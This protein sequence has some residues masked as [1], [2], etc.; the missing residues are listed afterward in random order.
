MK[1][2]GIPDQLLR[3]ISAFCSGRT[4]TI[5]VNGHTS[6]RRSL[7]QAGL[8]Q[9]SPLSPILF[10]FFNADLV[11]R[12]IDCYRGAIA[13]VDDFTAWVTG[14]TAESNREGIEAIINDALAWERR[15][16]ATFE[17]DMTAIIHF[18][19]KPYKTD[20]TPFTIKGQSVQP[21]THVK[22]LGVI[23]DAKLKYKEHI[24]RAAAKGLEAVIELRRLKGLSPATARQLFTATVAP[25][26]DYASNVWMHECRGPGNRRNV[27][28]CGDKRGRSRGT[29]CYDAGSVLEEGDQD[30]GGHSHPPPDKPPS[31]LHGADTEVQEIP[32]VAILPSGRHIKGHAHGET[33]NHSAVRAGTMGEPGAD[34]DRRAR[35]DAEHSPGLDGT[36]RREQLSKERSREIRGGR[37]D[38][39]VHESEPYVRDPCCHSRRKRRAEPVHRRTS[40]YCRHAALTTGASLPAHPFAHEE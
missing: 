12:R 29:H 13:F 18:A 33:R 34:G 39:D 24:A 36:H 8:P 9:G 16:G 15:S 32:P 38:K 28:D 11:Q 1:A 37:R 6:E 19:R 40:G 3:W 26:V 21:K 23:M 25:V 10:L 35:G 5:L 30:L 31:Q 17:A 7:P 20:S 14:P 4:A 2:R 27:H 22:I